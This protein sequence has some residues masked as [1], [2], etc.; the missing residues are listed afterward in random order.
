MESKLKVYNLSYDNSQ[1]AAQ[2]SNEDYEVERNELLMFL[3]KN[4][5]IDT[6][7]RFNI[8]NAEEDVKHPI[9]AYLVKTTM[10]FHSLLD[11]QQIQDLIDEEYKEK[12]FYILTEVQEESEDNYIAR[13]HGDY[14]LLRNSMRQVRKII[15]EA[16][17][18]Y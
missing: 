15:A 1:R 10:V 5:I 17:K 13:I 9:V 8:I 11:A 14:D 6:S 18:K 16:N 4:G 3:I 2:R 7:S 12:L